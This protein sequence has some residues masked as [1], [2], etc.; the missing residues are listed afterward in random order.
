VRANAADGTC[1]SSEGRKILVVDD[2]A[3]MRML[4]A[5]FLTRSG[6]VVIEARD[7]CAALRAIAEHRV[8]VVLL[9]VML[10]GIDGVEVCRRI[11]GDQATAHIPVLLVTALA[12]EQTRRRGLEAGAADVLGKPF[13][14]ARIRKAVQRLI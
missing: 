4:L 6:Y 9:D 5:A 7:G 10:P 13:T 2:S 3:T 12:D 14:A 1:T 11:K 8:A